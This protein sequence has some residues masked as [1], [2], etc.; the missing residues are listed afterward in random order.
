MSEQST[1]FVRFRNEVAV[2]CDGNVYAALLLEKLNYLLNEAQF[3]RTRVGD[4]GEERRYVQF[5]YEQ[6][7][8]ELNYRCPDLH[9]QRTIERALNLLRDKGFVTTEQ[10]SRSH[11]DCRLWWALV[12]EKINDALIDACVEGKIEVE[13]TAAQL[14]LFD[15]E[16][17]G[18]SA[19]Q[20]RSSQPSQQEQAASTDRN[21]GNDNVSSPSRQNGPSIST[22]GG[23]KD[24]SKTPPPK[25]PPSHRSSGSRSDSSSSESDGPPPAPTWPDDPPKP[26]GEE[27]EDFSSD[28]SLW[29]W[30][31]YTAAWSTGTLYDREQ[32]AHKH[33]RTARQQSW[34][35]VVDAEAKVLFDLVRKDGYSPQVVTQVVRHVLHGASCMMTAHIH[36]LEYLLKETSSSSKTRFEAALAL[37]RTQG[38]PERGAGH[39][40]PTAPHRS[41]S[42]NR[43]GRDAPPDHQG[44]PEDDQD[45]PEDDVEETSD[46]ESVR[47]ITQEFWDEHGGES[48]SSSTGRSRRQRQKDRFWQ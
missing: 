12:P 45:D 41:R 7:T 3:G 14:E 21:G 32:L 10:F 34:K 20:S 19:A 22:K 28:S 13:T 39:S 47:E 17:R 16:R 33:R 46:I 9:C 15:P 37:T 38:R 43:Q 5:S 1:S 18:R 25:S 6:W 30:A 31:W 48:S 26:V 23:P 36:S 42:R 11:G 27:E 4:D 8:E 29:E 24:S 44:D 35:A 40:S 2:I